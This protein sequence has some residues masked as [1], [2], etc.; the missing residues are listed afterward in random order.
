VKL[1][2]GAKLLA[3]STV[4]ALGGIA[5]AAAPAHALS[6][7]GRTLTYL[8]YLGVEASPSCGSLEVWGANY[9]PG[10]WVHVELLDFDTTYGFGIEIGSAYV[11]AE[12]LSTRP[13]GWIDTT[14]TRNTRLN[15]FDSHYFTAVAQDGTT[16]AQSS[17][18]YC[19]G[20]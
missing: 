3:V 12:N 10:D 4:V 7:S 18:V 8:P 20:L 13:Y 16:T 1:L 6:T 14:F 15:P 2:R 11:Q 17:S 19:P 5:A 9:T